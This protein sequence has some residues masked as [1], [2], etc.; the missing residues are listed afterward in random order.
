MG[1]DDQAAAY[2]RWYATP[3]GALAD[4]VEKEALF[5]LMPPVARLRLLEVG[6]APAGR[7]AG[8]A[9]RPQ[10]LLHHE[11]RRVE[12]I[13]GVAGSVKE[14]VAAYRAGRYTLAKEPEVTAHWR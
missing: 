7:G 13:V 5:A 1:F 12:V 8:G 10:S 4:R 2:D 6:A 14:A 11:G 3:L 9:L